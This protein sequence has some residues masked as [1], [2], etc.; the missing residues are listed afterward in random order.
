MLMRTIGVIPARMGSSRFPGKPLAQI[1]GRPMIEHVFRRAASAE[2]LD[3]LFVATCDEEIGRAAA[4]FGART[5]M[6]SAAHE[7][8]TDRVAEAVAGHPAD[9]VVMV[10][11]DEPMIQPSM[12]EAAVTPML[13]D[14]SI[15]CVNLGAVIRSHSELTNPNTIKAVVGRDARVLYLSREPIPTTRLLPFQ[16][17]R[18]VKQVCVIS[19]RRDALEQF[20]RFPTG[21][22]EAAE[23]IDM[24]RFLENDVPVHMVRTDVETHAVDTPFDL[25]EVE[26]LMGRAPRSVTD[27][28]D[29]SW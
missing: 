13:D 5:I 6:T 10:Q 24:L 9:V 12:I 27:R 28:E 22:L 21:P 7:R 3:E 2:I 16:V 11:G 4:S 8:A 25:R 19:F 14:P 26:L 17:G 29:S 23:S 18:W 1:S 20:A 15:R